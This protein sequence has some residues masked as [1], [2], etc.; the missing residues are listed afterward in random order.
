VTP[1]SMVDAWGGPK[2]CRSPAGAVAAILIVFAA[3][4]EALHVIPSVPSAVLSG[5]TS[6]GRPP[7]MLQ[8]SVVA[9]KSPD[10]WRSA[11][12][13][14]AA[15]RSRLRGGGASSLPSDLLVLRGAEADNL[16][17]RAQ[18]AGLPPRGLSAEQRSV[19][20][21]SISPAVRAAACT[22]THRHT[23]T[24]THTHRERERERERDCD[25][26]AYCR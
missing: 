6:A 17:S 26:Y 16:D 25:A 24:H 8:S 9:A 12:S 18:P 14:K 5:T 23:H 20:M 19:A 2:V 13:E 11:R 7:S 10:G 3:G 1:Q 22:H 21:E 4:M 15:K